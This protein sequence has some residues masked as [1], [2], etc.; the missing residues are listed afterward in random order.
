MKT[1]IRLF[2]LSFFSLLFILATVPAF[3]NR[4]FSVCLADTPTVVINEIAWMGTT[5][6]ANAE[7]IELYNSGNQSVDLT[8]WVLAATDGTPTISLSGAIPAQTFFL[9]ERTSNETVPGVIA[10]QIYTGAMGNGG[11]N[12]ELKGLSGALVDSVNCSSGWFS[13]D[14]DT[15]QTMEKISSGLPSNNKISWQES[16]SP[17]GTPKAQNSLGTPTQTNEGQPDEQSSETQDETASSTLTSSTA[18]GD[19]TTN[20]SP[21]ANAGPD[22]IALA[23]QEITFDA[24]KSSDPDGDSLAYLWNFGDGTT[25]DEPV[26][27]HSYQYPGTYIIVLE[28]SD[29]QNNS[30]DQAVITIYSNSILISEFMPAPAGAD[31]DNEWIELYNDSDRVADLSGWQVDDIDGG[32]KPFTIPQNT[33][34]AGHQYLVLQR[35]TTKIALNNDTDSVRLI[36]P[37]GQVTQEIQYAKA[38]EGQSVSLAV[39]GQY[40]WNSSPTPG[41]PN[42]IGADQQKTSNQIS[43]NTTQAGANT[44]SIQ[45]LIPQTNSLTVSQ[46]KPTVNLTPQTSASAPAKET[47]SSPSDKKSDKTNNQT[48]SLT[49]T[50]KSSPAT[51]LLLIIVFGV[52]SGLGLIKIRRKRGI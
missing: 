43:A 50:I 31:G 36:Y 2:L 40:I 24:A 49:G 32:S 18:S 33:L 7:W 12:L 35:S 6:S 47:S 51:T 52:L 28:A 1:L 26:I 27:N 16:T 17:D 13:G 11:E 3:M 34:L 45:S 5:E 22:I 19:S 10:D 29:G 30:S 37:T 42:F 4:P 23:N 25:S 14:N 9:L 21:E 39:A 20:H 48:A 41:G 15:K 38:K 46:E 44:E 8:D